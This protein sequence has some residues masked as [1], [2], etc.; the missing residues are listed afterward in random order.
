M[1]NDPYFIGY[2]YH[3]LISIDES[4]DPEKE[5]ESRRLLAKLSGCDV[6]D[7]LHK[8]TRRLL[9]EPKYVIPDF[10]YVNVKFTD[11]RCCDDK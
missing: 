2:K 11:E 9:F 3:E 7:S 5:N 1:T 8:M 10:K 4:W 6:T